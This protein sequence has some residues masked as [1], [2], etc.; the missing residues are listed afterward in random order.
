MEQF[1]YDLNIMGA[2]K[3]AIVLSAQNIMN[4]TITGPKIFAVD[5][6]SE[7]MNFAYYGSL[8]PVLAQNM[9]SIN[10]VF[11]SS[12]NIDVLH[13][14]YIKEIP[15]EWISSI[16]TSFVLPS[17]ISMLSYDKVL[18]LNNPELHK[19]SKLITTSRQFL[20]KQDGKTIGAELVLDDLPAIARILS[21][22]KEEIDI[23]KAIVKEHG[24]EK[25]DNWL[26]KLYEE[27]NNVL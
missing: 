13:Q 26:Q 5:N 2:V 1:E 9:S 18:N 7:L 16:N 19:L 8:F 4:T 22:E 21:S 3:A 11:V 17:E 27:L 6:L 24:D 14:L 10:G 25:V 15:Q 20:I 23:Y 12:V